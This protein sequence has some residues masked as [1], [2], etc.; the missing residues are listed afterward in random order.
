MSGQLRRLRRRFNG[1]G[2]PGV[3]LR[4]RRSA[5]T[6]EGTGRRRR[7]LVGRAAALSVRRFHRDTIAVH[8]A[9][10]TG[11]AIPAATEIPNP[12]R[13]AAT[14][15]AGRRTC[16]PR[17]RQSIRQPAFRRVGGRVAALSVDNRLPHR[18]S[19]AGVRACG[20]PCRWSADSHSRCGLP[21]EAMTTGP[22]RAY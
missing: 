6:I 11:Q 4:A 16:I 12:C 21:R 14:V 20:I 15:P 7:R 9:V 19:F 10:W 5:D 3:E 13:T 17:Q 2:S 1:L 8:P 22:V 18:D